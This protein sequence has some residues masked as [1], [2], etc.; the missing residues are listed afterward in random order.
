MP[1]P[2]P[3]AGVKGRL[4]FSNTGDNGGHCLAIDTGS[5]WKRIVLDHNVGATKSRLQTMEDSATGIVD[6]GRADVQHLEATDI[7]G[8]SASL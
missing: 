7:D 5:D 4:F 6:G 1:N 8:G 3:T 2:L